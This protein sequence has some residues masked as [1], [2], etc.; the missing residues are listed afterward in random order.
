M[1]DSWTR[2]PGLVRR[3]ELYVEAEERVMGVDLQHKWMEISNDG[4]K[5]KEEEW[6]L[7][8]FDDADSSPKEPT[9]KIS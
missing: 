7:P 3:F 2:R 4:G 8:V 1:S 9:T 6:D 5:T